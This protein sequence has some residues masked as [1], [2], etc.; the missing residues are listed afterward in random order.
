MLELTTNSLA[1]SATSTYTP[2][3]VNGQRVLTNVW[4]SGQSLE[5]IGIR[6]HIIQSTLGWLIIARETISISTSE[7]EDLIWFR[8]WIQILAMSFHVLRRIRLM[9]SGTWTNGILKIKIDTFTK[10]TVRCGMHAISP[11]APPPPLPATSI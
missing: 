4:P 2:K 8:H 3:M 10:V 1:R 7:E 5:D 11:P 6:L 9:E